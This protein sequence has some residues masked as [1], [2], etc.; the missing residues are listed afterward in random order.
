MPGVRSRRRR[1]PPRDVLV[2]V[3]R[4]RPRPDEAHVTAEH[5]PELRQLVEARVAQETS[6][7]R[8]ARV[9]LEQEPDR[10]RALFPELLSALVR[11]RDHGAELEHLEAS[12]APAPDALLNEEDR[13]AELQRYR[14]EEHDRREEHEEP[15]GDQNVHSALEGARRTRQ[16]RRR[17][18]EH[19]DSLDVVDLNR[20]AENVDHVGEEPEADVEAAQ[21]PDQ[22]RE[23]VLVDLRRE[24][25]D[26]LDALAPADG[27]DVARASQVGE[28]RQAIVARALPGVDISDRLELVLGVEAQLPRENARDGAAADEQDAFRRDDEPADRP[29]RGAGEEHHPDAD[30]EEDHSLGHVQGRG[31]PVAEEQPHAESPEQERMEDPRQVV[32]GRVAHA[33]CVAVVEPVDL[34]E[35]DPERQEDER[36][37]ELAEH[38][39]D[40][41]VRRAERERSD[42]PR[43][44]RGHEQPAKQI[45]TICASSRCADDTR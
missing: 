11:I 34:E 39:A 26:A 10:V 22:V 35:Q 2:H 27:R 37:E 29:G 24:D 25:Q 41:K 32:H 28:T 33:L 43:H 4:H 36:P 15:E 42:D 20:G 16:A 44:V 14:D 5:V 18:T 31:R 13:P 1:A 21:A 8:D 3:G 7:A 12:A 30:P 19:G 6:E 23:L 45:V 17:Q 40:G 9:V 38:A